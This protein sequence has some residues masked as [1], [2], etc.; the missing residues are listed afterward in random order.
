MTQY[1]WVAFGGAI[2]AC[3]RFWISSLVNRSTSSSFPYGT[4][5]VNLAGSFLFGLLFVW[6][7]S[8]TSV[9]EPLRLLILVGGLGAF[10]T[11][12]T[13]SFETIRLIE[14]GMLVS[15]LINVVVSCG[16]CLLG[17]W[18]GLFFARQLF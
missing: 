4:L 13:F 1:L 5:T 14:E 2:G 16:L 10:T 3:G 18:A 12:S 7:F 15:A 8:L 17:V 6:V 9:R 11:F